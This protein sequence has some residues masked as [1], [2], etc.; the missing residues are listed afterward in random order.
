MFTS[1][2][3]LQK[4]KDVWAYA[5]QEWV[6]EPFD[7]NPQFQKDNQAKHNKQWKL[8]ARGRIVFIMDCFCTIYH[9]ALINHGQVGTASW[10][11]WVHLTK[12]QLCPQVSA[13]LPWHYPHWKIRVKPMPLHSTKCHKERGAWRTEMT[14]LMG[15]SRKPWVLLFVSKGSASIN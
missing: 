7:G 11:H 14:V 1:G 5:R 3:L 12:Q 15:S 8:I 6:S 9:P 4:T 10:F 2:T 13:I